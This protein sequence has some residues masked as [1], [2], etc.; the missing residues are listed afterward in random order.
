MGTMQV[1]QTMRMMVPMR[2]MVEISKKSGDV[3]WTFWGRSF[4]SLAAYDFKTPILKV[5]TVRI[6]RQM[7]DGLTSM[8]TRY[9]AH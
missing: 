6:R 1:N 8:N 9:R 7:H 2:A 4:P 3:A 5:P